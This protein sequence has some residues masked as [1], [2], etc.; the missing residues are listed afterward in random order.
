MDWT[1]TCVLA[2]A[3]SIPGFLTASLNKWSMSPDYDPTFSAGTGYTLQLQMIISGKADNFT[4]DDLVDFGKKFDVADPK[5]V[6]ERTVDAFSGSAVPGQRWKVAPRELGG[7]P[8]ACTCLN[9]ER[10]G[11]RLESPRPC[12]RGAHGR[13]LLR[14]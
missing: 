13:S 11:G 1:A 8:G 9:S 4:V 3:E 10:L 2:L 12:P 14:A 5:P 6:I 7:A